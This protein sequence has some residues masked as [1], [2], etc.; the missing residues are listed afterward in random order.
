M[1]QKVSTICTAQQNHKYKNNTHTKTEEN[2]FV[3][4]V[5]TIYPIHTALAKQDHPILAA[6]C[7][8][9]SHCHRF[10]CRSAISIACASIGRATI[11]KY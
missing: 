9:L 1:P 7:D 11:L 6:N 2:T 4:L 5:D 3:Y 8:T 10:F